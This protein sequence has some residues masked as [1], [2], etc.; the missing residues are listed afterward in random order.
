MKKMILFLIAAFL[1]V[2]T[3][4]CMIVVDDGEDCAVNLKNKTS[5]VCC[6]EKCLPAKIDIKNKD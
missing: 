6:V 2:L 3:T 4:S 5:H 1:F